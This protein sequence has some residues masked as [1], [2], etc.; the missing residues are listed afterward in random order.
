M[1][2]Y[3]ALKAATTDP[4]HHAT[5]EIITVF[6]PAA[7]FFKLVGQENT[8]LCEL[9]CTFFSAVD[10]MKICSSLIAAGLDFTKIKCSAVD[11]SDFF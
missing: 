2:R 3:A 4:Q 5:E 6:L 7:L 8:E 9:G 10:K 11:H 1:D